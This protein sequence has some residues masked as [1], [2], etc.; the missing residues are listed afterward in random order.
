MAESWADFLLSYSN[1]LATLVLILFSPSWWHLRETVHLSLFVQLQNKLHVTSEHLPALTY[2]LDTDL[3]FP[4]R[5]SHPSW[6]LVQ[7]HGGNGEWWMQPTVTYFPKMHILHYSEIGNIKTFPDK[8]SASSQTPWQWDGCSQAIALNHFLFSNQKD[9]FILACAI[10][11]K[12]ISFL[13]NIPG[14]FSVPQY[15]WFMLNLSELPFR[16]TERLKVLQAIVRN[17]PKAKT[18]HYKLPN[19]AFKPSTFV[20]LFS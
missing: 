19:K 1:G 17:T 2:P 12:P 20:R 18:K 7:E 13:S 4:S 15:L 16:Q 5:A 14:K 11:T 9:N 8:H 10:K 3:E 6:N